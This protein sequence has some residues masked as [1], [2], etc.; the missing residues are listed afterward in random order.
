MTSRIISGN[1]TI[2]DV[3]REHERKLEKSKV[4]APQPRQ[5]APATPARNISDPEN[6]IALP[7]KAHGTYSYPDLLVPIERTHQNKDWDDAQAALR[8]EGYFMLTI[9]QFIDY[10]NLLKSG[11]AYYGSGRQIGKSELDAILF[12]IV[13]VKDPWRAEWL[14]AKF[15]KTIIFGENTITYHKI[16]TYGTLEEV[17]EPL[18]DCLMEDKLP[19]ISLDYWLQNATPQGLPPKKTPK[20]NFWYWRPRQG[21]VAGFVAHSGGA[22]LSCSG[23][24]QYVYSA[25]GVRAAKVK[26]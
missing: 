22:V 5:V 16:K 13:G 25:F 7:G 24:L 15:G 3:I 14:D 26:P 12:D 11:T 6:Y 10:I 20:G 21:Y 19:G 2:E 1:R 8:A 4:P 18:Q 17:T 23:D 9:R